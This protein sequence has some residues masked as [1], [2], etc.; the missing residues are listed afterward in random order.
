MVTFMGLSLGSMGLMLLFWLAVLFL[1]LWLQSCLFPA[2]LD[3]SPPTSL[4]S[5]ISITSNQQ[6][7]SQIDT[8]YRSTSL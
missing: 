6:L 7:P 4:S 5:S 3:T 2:Y 1:A 8:G